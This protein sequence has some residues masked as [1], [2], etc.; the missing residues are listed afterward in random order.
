M[1]EKNQVVLVPT[2]ENKLCTN[3]CY[4][5][6]LKMLIENNDDVLPSVSDNLEI[7]P[8]SKKINRY[9]KLYLAH[10]INYIDSND[11]QDLKES[12]YYKGRRDECIS[13]ENTNCKTFTQEQVDDMLDRQACITTEQVLANT[14]SE[15]KVIQLIRWAMQ[16]KG[17]TPEYEVQSFCK[18]HNL[19]YPKY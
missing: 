19:D 17:H 8:L 2:E 7:E 3:W 6:E 18:E 9:H 11:V 12:Y 14:Y 5:D 4:A 13:N 16:S 15:E 1:T 10:D